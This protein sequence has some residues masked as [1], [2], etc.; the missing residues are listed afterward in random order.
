MG[1]FKKFSSGLKKTRESM[2]NTI[3]NILNSFS[4]IDDDLFDELEEALVL[5]DV[6]VNTS[7]KAISG[8]AY[9]PIL[10]FPPL[11]INPIA[12]VLLIH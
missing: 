1:I 10:Y 6:G 5:G 2:S 8:C 9:V 11:D 12:F 3:T 4:A 7:T